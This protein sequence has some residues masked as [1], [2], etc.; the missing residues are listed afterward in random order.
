[1]SDNSADKPKISVIIPVFNCEKFLGR[2]LSSIVN[3]TFKDLEIIVINDGSTDNS[4]NIIESFDDNRIKYYYQN[5]SGISA[6]RNKGMKLANGEYIS[7]IDSDDWL[8]N[9]YFEKMYSTAIK[10]NADI[11]VSGIIRLHK[12]HKKYILKFDKETVTDNIIEKIE[13][14][15]VPEKSY[16]WNKLYKADVLKN[17][18]IKFAVNRLYEDVLFTPQI[19]NESGY[20]ITVPNTYYYYWRHNNSIVTQ[21]SEKAQKDSH[22]MQ[23]LRDE[24]LRENGINIDKFR[25]AYKR[26]KIFGITVFKVKT[27]GDTKEY[28]LFNIFRWQV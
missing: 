20:L 25:V 13:L 3:Q 15:G 18:N 17:S 23:K 6:T 7:F 26:Y 8:D 22:D 21:K 4:K 2:C 1:M 14:C 16:V 27:K 9:N 11:A 5:N 12:A 10:Y 28:S 19:L 24:Y